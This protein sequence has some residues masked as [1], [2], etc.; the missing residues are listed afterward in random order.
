M[1]NNNT[2]Q[3]ELTL[4]E[5]ILAIQDYARYFLRKWYWFV[6]GAVV[7]GGVFFWNAYTTPVTYSAPLTFLLNNDKEKS[8]GAGA[9][10]GGLGLGTSET[11]GGTAAKLLELSK[12]RQVL[13]RVLFDSAS[14]DGKTQFV[15]DHLIDVYNYHTVWKDSKQLANFSFRGIPPQVEDRV[16][17]RVFKSLHNRM[18]KEEDGILTVMLDEMTG[19]FKIQAVTPNPELSIA[20]TEKVYDELTSYFI[21]A[22][23]SDK[24][25]SLS[26]LSFR[27]D[28]V[29]SALAV[30]E[31]RFAR[32]QDRAGRIPLQEQSIKGQQLQREV[33]ILGTMYSEIVK[34]RETAAFLLANEKPG[35]ELVDGPLEP[36]SVSGGSV[37]RGVVLGGAL[38]MVL[39]VIILFFIKLVNDAMRE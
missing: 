22:S 39:T 36:L 26:L 28:S 13:G 3:D 29:K 38:G 10:L 7:L 32:F 27:A 33:L 31:G 12:S 19:L 15:A 30:A 9:I 11:G 18:V 24:E 21:N 4:K 37:G 2:L 17:N 25:N 5:L 8:V 16:A 34:N 14:V 35:F 23:V 20:I 6:L 1:D